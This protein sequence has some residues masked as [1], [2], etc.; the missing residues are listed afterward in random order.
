MNE[1]FIKKPLISED[2]DIQHLCNG[3][4]LFSVLSLDVFVPLMYVSLK[5]DKETVAVV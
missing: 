2:T 4:L 5:K 3:T 1:I